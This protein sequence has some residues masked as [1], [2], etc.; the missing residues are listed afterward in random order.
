MTT[1]NNPNDDHMLISY[2]A[3][4]RVIGVI[5]ITLPIVLVMVGNQFSN[6]GI[7]DSISS[8]YW[9]TLP[10]FSWSLATRDILVGSLCVIGVFLGS[11]RGDKRWDNMAGTLACFFA[12]GV[13]LF[14][15]SKP[16]EDR[17]W[18][19][20]VHYASAAGL[21]LMLAYFCLISFRGSDP[22]T[23]PTEKKPLRNRVYATCG[24]IILLCIALIAIL[25][26]FPPESSV[27][28]YVFWLEASAIW[29]FGWSWYI[30]G[31]GLGIIQD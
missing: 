24:V 20:Y 7:Q 21:F 18:Y 9:L 15:C 5:G 4:R 30:K 6:A 29:A 23:T 10:D 13:A 26:I 1:K 25:G 28:N 17:T 27:K 16:L 11:Y 2:R 3:L 14:P 19:N 31:K 12:V 22:G 8:Y